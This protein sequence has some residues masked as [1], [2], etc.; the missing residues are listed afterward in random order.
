MPFLLDSARNDKQLLCSLR[1]V[2]LHFI[3]TKRIIKRKTSSNFFFEGEGLKPLI[4]LEIFLLEWLN[5]RCKCREHIVMHPVVPVSHLTAEPID[6]PSPSVCKAERCSLGEFKNRNNCAK[7]VK[8]KEFH[9]SASC[10][11]CCGPF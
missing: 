1:H 5:L 3:V 10:P 7:Q 4:L 8:S 6:I 11:A 9:D 2:C